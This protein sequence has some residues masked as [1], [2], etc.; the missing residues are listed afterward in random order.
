[1]A[2]ITRHVHLKTAFDF[3]PIDKFCPDLQV[4]EPATNGG[5]PAIPNAI[6]FVDP[7]GETHIFRLGE[8]H[9]RALIGKLTGGVMV[10]PGGAG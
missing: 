8:E 3:G 9:R 1:M 4:R 2:S 7:D 6:C 10:V 5:E